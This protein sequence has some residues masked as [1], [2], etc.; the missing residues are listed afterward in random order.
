MKQYTKEVED[1]I[2]KNVLPKLGFKEITEDNIDDI[3]DYLLDEYEVPLGAKS[4][5]WQKLSKEEEEELRLASKCITEI[6]TDPDWSE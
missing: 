6:T 5:S 4:D 2:K 1:F 3:V